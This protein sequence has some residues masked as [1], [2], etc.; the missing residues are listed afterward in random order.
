MEITSKSYL[1]ELAVAQQSAYWRGEPE[2]EAPAEALEQ[3]ESCAIEQ[4]DLVE[5]S[6]QKAV[7]KPQSAEATGSVIPVPCEDVPLK[8]A[9]CGSWLTN[10]NEHG[11]AYASSHYNGTNVCDSC[12]VEHC[13]ATEC[14]QCDWSKDPEK[15]KFKSMRE[16]YLNEPD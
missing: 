14:D 5:I 1:S 11:M 16:F 6:R 4:V 3:E 8:C 10:I 12:F 2:S 15:C 9:I 7:L 13:C